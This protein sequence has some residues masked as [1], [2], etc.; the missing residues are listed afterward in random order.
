MSHRIMRFGWWTWRYIYKEL[1]VFDSCCERKKIKSLERFSATWRCF[2][3]NIIIHECP[4][5][6]AECNIFLLHQTLLV[7]ITI[8]FAIYFPFWCVC[9]Y[10]SLNTYQVEKNKHNLTFLWSLTLLKNSNHALYMY[11]LNESNPFV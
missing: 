8:P 7:I 11:Q 3:I 10:W 1:L 9:R 2:M 5:I 4:T 6:V